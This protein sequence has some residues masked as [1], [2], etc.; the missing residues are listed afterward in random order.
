MMFER[1]RNRLVLLLAALWLGQPVLAQPAEQVNVAAGRIVTVPDFPS[2]QI[3]P[4]TVWVWLPAAYDRDATQ[5]FPVIYMH[6][7]QNLFD[8]KRA[9]YGQ[10]W[11][12][13]EA[14]SRMAAAGQLRAHIVVGIAS[15][16]A[17][18]A[19]LFP[20]KLMA[21]LTPAVQARV[22]AMLNNPDMGSS[23]A[24]QGD[25]YLKFLTR[26]LKPWVDGRFRTLGGRADTSV[27]GASMGGLMSLYAMGEYPDVFG[28]AAAVSMHLP[29]ADP[30]IPEGERAA[31]AQAVAD[32]F[33]TWL[34]ATKLD[35]KTHRF[36]RDHGTAT[37]DQFYPP[38]AAAFDAMMASRG[39]RWPNFEARS[40]T[41]TAHNE[42]AWAERV[43]IPLL[44][45]D[46]RSPAR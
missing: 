38:Y 23:R 6:D 16:K 26:E 14:I 24:L 32:A 22:Q 34:A 21:Q 17:R 1:V 33:G 45:L 43:D 42:T 28:Q 4:L 44:F 27:M 15:P 37:L 9:G 41:G 30:N 25:A 5:S 13:D 46:R 3:D 31:A 10:E 29:L 18:F 7:G 19:A 40:F 2:K 12:M 20:E 8:A 39:W 11:Q 35:P 36:Y